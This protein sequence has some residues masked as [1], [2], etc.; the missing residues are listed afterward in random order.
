VADDLNHA[1][2]DPAEN[3]LATALAYRATNACPASSTAR[4]RAVP[5]ELVRPAVKEIAVLPK[6][7]R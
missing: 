2:G 5:M 7:E 3:L 6:R 1:L 4:A